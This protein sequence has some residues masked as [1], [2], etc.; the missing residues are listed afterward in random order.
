MSSKRFSGILIPKLATFFVACYFAD[1]FWDIL[2]A[3]LYSMAG[4][5]PGIVRLLQLPV[6]YM[7][8]PVALCFAIGYV[9]GFWREATA[10][11]NKIVTGAICFVMPAL[12]LV[13]ALIFDCA[14][15]KLCAA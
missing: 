2:W 15:L 5:L 11:I 1:F 9:Y 6:C 3:K 14:L 8:V 12:A 7:I 13:P 4:A 10:D